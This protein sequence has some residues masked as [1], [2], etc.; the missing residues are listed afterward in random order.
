MTV[1]SN[2]AIA[3]ATLNGRFKN[4]VPVLSTRE[5]C[6]NDF[7]RAWSKLHGNATNLDWFITPFA[8][9]ALHG[10]NIECACINVMFNT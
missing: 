9:K 10:Q 7:S 1:K 2:D 3:I 5:A 4:L 6:T 8:L